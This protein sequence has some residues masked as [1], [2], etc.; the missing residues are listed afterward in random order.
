MRNYY[1][2]YLA[3]GT[4]AQWGDAVPAMIEVMRSNGL[5]VLELEDLPG[6]ID[7]AWRVNPETLALERVIPETT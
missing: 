4:I 3:S 1:C 7:T 6:D 2:R 5:L